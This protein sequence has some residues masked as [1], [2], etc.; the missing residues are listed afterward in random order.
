MLDLVVTHE[1]L[2]KLTASMDSFISP[3]ILFA[4]MSTGFFLTHQVQNFGSLTQKD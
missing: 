2:V 3:L 1:E 4:L